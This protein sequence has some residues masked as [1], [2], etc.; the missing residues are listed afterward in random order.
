MREAPVAATV[1]ES[2]VFDGVVPW[3]RKRKRRFKRVGRTFYRNRIEGEGE[4][5]DTLLCK[6]ATGD[7]WS[8]AKSNKVEDACQ[9]R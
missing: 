5:I 8:A 3:G 2:R 6:W 4:D 1:A 7:A 9:S